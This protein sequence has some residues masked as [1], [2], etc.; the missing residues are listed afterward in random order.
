MNDIEK[1]LH[2]QNVGLSD[3]ILSE[4]VARTKQ[5][6]FLKDVKNFVQSFADRFDDLAQVL[7]MHFG[8]IIVLDE[9]EE[10]ED[11]NHL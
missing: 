11:I 2:L 8:V 1:N 7:K 10:F 9:T 6:F 3:K 5:S 4:I